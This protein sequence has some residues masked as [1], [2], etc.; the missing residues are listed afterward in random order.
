MLGPRPVRRA[1]SPPSPLSPTRRGGAPRHREQY[2]SPVSDERAD[3]VAFEM[4]APA[5]RRQFDEEDQPGD[6]AADQLAFE[7]GRRSWLYAGDAG[8][9]VEVAIVAQHLL[10]MEALH[11]RDGQGVSEVKAP[12]F[13]V[14]S[15]RL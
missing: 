2:L 9:G 13:S 1:P 8:D 3:A 12:L 5:E 15:E 10:D 4:L 11:V 7:V 6:T 14:D